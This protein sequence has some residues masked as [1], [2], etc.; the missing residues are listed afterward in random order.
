MKPYIRNRLWIV[1]IAIGLIIFYKTDFSMQAERLYRVL[2][3][4]II[5]MLF[6]WFL[7]P[8]KVWGERFIAGNTKGKLKNRA[9]LI[10]AFAVYFAFVGV[11][12][13]FIICLIPVIKSGVSN[14][15]EQFYSYRHVFEKFMNGNTLNS[16]LE[17]INPRVYITGAKNTISLLFDGAMSFV[18]L[19]YI[20][21]EHRELKKLFMKI[22]ELVSGNDRAEKL[23]YYFSRTNSIFSGYFYSKFISSVFLGLIVTAG[24]FIC[25]ISHPLFFGT[26]VGLFNMLPVFGTFI[27]SVPIALLTFAEFGIYRAIA[28]IVV[29]VAGQQIENSILTPKIVG[30]RV[31]LSGLWIIVTTLAG[32]GLFGFWG[33]LICV[34]VAATFKM[35]FEEL[36]IG[37]EE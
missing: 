33:L 9:H 16:I 2:L 7:I 4:V 31:G 17:K 12:A 22:L 8:L 30:D 14:A 21:L 1:G 15:V 34:P 32:G 27:S 28:S 5:A 10:S 26:V 11:V 35:L 18:V 20:L 36:V 3:P 19:I 29:I 37:N 24:F 25:G 23:L 6:S 13:F